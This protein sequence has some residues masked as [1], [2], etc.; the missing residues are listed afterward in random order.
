[1]S[2]KRTPDQIKYLIIHCSATPNGKSFTAADIDSWHQ[3]RGFTRDMS[4]YPYHAP[5]LKHIGYHFVIRVDGTPECG[6]YVLETGAHCLGYNTNGIGI[7]MVGT[8][9]FS[10]AQWRTLADQVDI[11]KKHYPGLIVLGHR[12]TSPDTNGNG[13]VDPQEWLKTCPGFDVNTWLTGRM[14]PL[15]G[16]IL[17][18]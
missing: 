9:Q 8:D 7:C 6:R 16:H 18:H 4:L 1:M 3:Q 15:T 12:D 2:K 14:E 11:F 13:R 5:A 10:P 17:E